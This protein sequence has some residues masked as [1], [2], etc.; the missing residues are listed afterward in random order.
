M[1]EAM[2]TF[3]KHTVAAV[4]KGGTFDAGYRFV[5]IAPDGTKLWYEKTQEEAE[6]R[7][8]EA[9]RILEKRNR[10]AN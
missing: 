7:A 5:V 6:A 3:R 9:D 2:T 10:P 8:A 1:G 4:I